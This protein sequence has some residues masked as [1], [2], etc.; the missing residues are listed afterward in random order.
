MFLAF[1]LFIFFAVESSLGIGCIVAGILGFV[2]LAGLAPFSKKQ[3]KTKEQTEAMQ[4][5]IDFALEYIERGEYPPIVPAGL[6]HPIMLQAN[7]KLLF[8]SSATR[9]IT[10]NKAVGRTASGGGVRVRVAKGVSV[11]SGSGSSRTIY[12]D[13]TTR[14]PGQF[15]ITTERMIFISGREGFETKLNKISSLVTHTDG[16]TVQIGAKAY[17]LAVPLC[18]LIKPLIDLAI[19]KG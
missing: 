3:H 10:K 19:T 9:L 4:R 2:A 16:I 7:E 17:M 13:V 8:F 12:N 1:A 11:G 15:A 5:E 14:Y 6:Q 18:Q